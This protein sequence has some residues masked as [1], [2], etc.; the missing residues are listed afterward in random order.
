MNNR[1]EFMTM[2]AGAT[3]FHATRASPH[4]FGE[5]PS[6]ATVEANDLKFARV[7]DDFTGL[8]YEMPQLYNP[9]FFSASNRK[10]VEAYRGLSGNGVLRLGGNLSDLAR[11]KSDAGDFPTDKQTAAIEHGKTYWEWKLTDQSVRE[12]REGAIT[13]EAIRNLK[14][15]LDATNWRLIYGLNFGSGTPERAADEAACVAREI[16][17]RLIAFQVGNESDFF[18]GNRFYRE[19]GFNI[20]GYLSGYQE[21]ANA[22]RQRTPHAPFAGPDT[23]NNMGW[24]DEFAKRADKPVKLLSSHYYAMG[25]AKNPEMDAQRLLSPNPKLEQQIEQ[26]RQ[27]VRDSGDTPFRMTEGNSCYGGGKPGVS[28]AFASALWG[29]DYML[30]VASGGYAG[31]NL[32]GGGDGIYTPIETLDSTTASLRPIYYGM[33]FANHFAGCE[34]A[35][36]SFNGA[37]NATAYLGRSKGVTQL[38]LINKSSQEI[39]PRIGPGITLKKRPKVWILTAPSL[40][41]KQN[42]SFARTTTSS[43]ENHIIAPYSATLLVWE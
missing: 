4:L 18:G 8:S 6:V 2:A 39:R 22:V 32:H 13:P 19:R 30:R 11:W 34:V 12:N 33:Q 35:Q 20:D 29:A 40:D 5:E 36:C 1:R 14:T 27:A 15:F 10:L 41:A 38:A 17:D 42:I 9:R 31:V 21:F 3:L 43:S 23:A 25:P 28:D 37:S 16:G 7:P 26:A 24:V